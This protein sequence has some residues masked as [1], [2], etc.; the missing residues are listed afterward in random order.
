MDI[1]TIVLVIGINKYQDK[2]IPSLKGASSDAV[3]FARALKN[4]GI[5][6]ANITLFLDDQA[7]K[8]NI[9]NYF[10]ALKKIKAPFKF[11]LHFCGHGQ[12]L[13][14]PMPRSYLLL[15]DSSST[16]ENS[17]PLDTITERIRALNTSEVY[18]FIDACQLMINNILNP[19]LE[20]EINGKSISKSFYC[21]LSAGLDSSFED[22]AEGVAGEY[23]Y[24]TDSL[25]RCLATHRNS[26]L[27]SSTLLNW[28]NQELNNKALPLTDMYNI[29][30][31]EIAFLP[32][33]RASYKGGDIV[34]RPTLLSD[35]QNALAFR[36]NKI[37]A[38]T[39]EA[40]S[41]KT[42]LVHQLVSDSLHSFYISLGQGPSNLSEIIF[43]KFKNKIRYLT[44]ALKLDELL[45]A[46]HQVFP[47]ALLIIDNY[48][49]FQDLGVLRASRLKFLLVCKQMFYE[50]NI[51]EY[52]LPPFSPLETSLLL[53]SAEIPVWDLIYLSAKGNPRKLKNLS[54]L[55]MPFIP[56]KAAV[57]KA[58]HALFSVRFV[59]DRPLF[60][61]LFGIEEN[62]LSFL[63][64][65]EILN[66]HESGWKPSE[67]V[68]YLAHYEKMLSDRAMALKYWHLLLR[69][70]KRS[71]KLSQK[72]E[73]S[74]QYVLALRH[75]GYDLAVDNYLEQIIL[76]F[77][78]LKEG[79][80]LKEAASIF[81]N[82]QEASQAC[83]TLTNVLM[84][85]VEFELAEQLL[86]IPLRSSKHMPNFRLAK[87]HF[88][89]R[90]GYV[91]EAQELFED[92]INETFNKPMLS[93]LHF[94]RGITYF[95]KAQWKDAYQD[96]HQSKSLSKD[97]SLQGWALC[98]LGTIQGL[99]QT[100]PKEAQQLFEEGIQ[101]LTKNNN[102]R[103]IW[104]GWNNLAEVYWK[105]G[106]YTK[107]SA[108]IT[109]ALEVCKDN[110]PL[111][112]QSLGNLLQIEARMSGFSS[113]ATGQ[114]IQMIKNINCNH[115]E[116]F[117]AVE[118]F[119]N[120]ITIH[121]FRREVD[122]ALL[123]MKGIHPEITGC[124]LMDV[125][126]FANMALISLAQQNKT[127]AFEYLEKAMQLTTK[128]QSL[129]IQKQIK[130][131]FEL[132]QKQS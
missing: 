104:L 106:D 46:I 113:T 16:G 48:V 10:S 77:S 17:F 72:R 126:T 79:V 78:S 102:Q 88:L 112:L 90:T 127:L 115:C 67:F 82:E 27:S 61:K 62:L 54:T 36:N 49:C 93:Q 100:H 11:V 55:E 120:L 12:R 15:H 9:E 56:K 94:Q 125:Y 130:E 81:I 129:L 20:D 1:P 124:K 64:K 116:W 84:E 41:G 103:G 70:H 40:G 44:P 89:W 50:K 66:V 109:K 30:T 35:L 97:I 111:K 45:E 47:A 25:L 21:L 39:G 122:E 101:L 75:L 14:T 91:N 123:L 96:F 6:E 51:C 18:V 24:F 80:I 92:I 57:K 114:L 73:L 2:L 107:A 38:L 43:R 5:P 83:L 52:K 108:C 3:L 105:Y 85:R 7:T 22:V 33:T 99:S 8:S 86:Q 74:Y 69:R 87:G 34:V 19:N 63:E 13:S 65:V 60:C 71:D 32:L 95:L 28:I 29:R 117:Q 118:L 132:F 23:G 121:L 42:S 131:D 59:I 26:T 37:V 119:N 76:D 31:S 58:I 53:N 98:M 68:D 128:T 4:W 110:E